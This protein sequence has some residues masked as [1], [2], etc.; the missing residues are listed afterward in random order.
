MKRISERVRR[1]GVSAVWKRSR[2]SAIAWQ[3]L[4]KIILHQGMLYTAAF[5]T[6]APLSLFLSA[7]FLFLFLIFI[8]NSQP[9]F[10]T[11][12]PCSFNLVCS[13]S[14]PW[15]VSSL[16]IYLSSSL[17]LFL[18]L[19]Q[20][21]VIYRAAQQYLSISTESV[22]GI[23]ITMQWKRHCRERER[24]RVYTEISSEE[25]S[26]I[27]S[28]ES[29]IIRLQLFT[30]GTLDDISLLGLSAHI[31]SNHTRVDSSEIRQK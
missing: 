4:P 20:L 15:I 24:E 26:Y 11:R 14:P 18:P 2:W 25:D 31:M 16:S 29:H 22:W 6:N 28:S 13:F 19:S 8:C 30:M 9:F 21:Q 12:S 10:Y 27:I 1:T 3:I 5:Y 17:F 7:I 23:I